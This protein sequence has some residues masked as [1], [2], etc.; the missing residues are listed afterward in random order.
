MENEIL[1][2]NRNGS[3]IMETVNQVS[4]QLLD[5]REESQVYHIVSEALR[6]ILP[7]AFF[8]VSKLQPDDMNFRVVETQGF[9]KF[10]TAIKLI[11]G[12]DPFKIDYPINDFTEDQLTGFEKR[13]IYHFSDG[14]FEL[15]CGALNRTVSK[16][17]EFLIG[18]K[19]V[20][21]MS[22]CVGK[23]YF[24]GFT[25]FITGRL[26]KDGMM[27]DETKLAIETIANHA[28]SVIQRFRSQEELSQKQ[29]ELTINH[30]RFSKLIG[31]LSDIVWEADAD[32]SNI[33]DLNNSFER[34]Y[35]VSAT[36]FEKNPSLW[37]DLAH[38]EDRESVIESGNELFRNG[39]SISEYRI[40]RKDGTIKW[41]LDRKSIIYDQN[42]KALEMRGIASDITE[43]KILEQELKIKNF[44]IDNSPT[45]TGL[46][47]LQGKIFY[48]NDAYVRLFGYFNK[49]EII[50]RPINEFAGS[51]EK[52]NDVLDSI[53]NGIQY[54][55]EGELITKQGDNLSIIISAAPVFNKGELLCYMALFT[56][57]TELK[58]LELKL[59]KQS[60]ELSD[61]LKTKNKFFSIISHDLRSPFNAI[62][63]FSTILL[64]EFNDL[65]DETRL[66]YIQMVYDSSN[67]AFKLLSN[68]L[69]WAMLD[70]GRI[71]IHKE[72][73]VLKEI[74][75]ECIQLYASIAF[76][77]NITVLNS[78]QEDISIFVDRNSILTILRN[79]LSNALKYTPSGGNITFGSV[80][81][82]P[83]I[84]ITVKDSGV[85]IS[86][87]VIG[88]LF[89]LAQ[90]KSTLGTNNEKG[91]GLG[92]ILCKELTEKNGG[93]ISVRSELGKQTEFII[94]LP[95]VSSKG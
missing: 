66:D 80:L 94:Q 37:V 26:I 84:E 65:D 42:G 25:L 82:H 57:I 56:N 9:E 95:M 7:G 71:E 58:Q 64:E 83:Y 76:N 32:G 33:K 79:L 72:F 3:S 67:N 41:L 60:E 21:G 34:F 45:A 61:L 87:E 8:L 63:G 69:E 11:A 14:V 78:I 23:K 16:A 59:R 31:Q 4:I 75:N 24:G 47:D 74:V 2:Q 36:E 39:K 73:I 5:A 44:A 43:R 50:G 38:P 77:K 90:N 54:I 85:G 68:L 22:F 55:G 89:K 51:Q 46:A 53:T 27:N 18:I 29:V 92:L 49:E 93:E 91:T 10:L 19:D 62:L 52:V 1:P 17:L 13:K 88:K 6:K 12:K 86:E 35:G 48:V 40:I 81:R 70:Q 30:E 15:A 28:S 20:Y